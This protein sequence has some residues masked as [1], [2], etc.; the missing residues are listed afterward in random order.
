MSPSLLTTWPVDLVGLRG[1]FDSKGVDP[2]VCNQRAEVRRSFARI[3]AGGGG[4]ASNSPERTEENHCSNMGRALRRRLLD[5]ELQLLAYQC[6]R[7]RSL[8]ELAGT[9]DGQAASGEGGRI[10]G[11]GGDGSDTAAIGH[12]VD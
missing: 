7:S 4:R 2:D 5:Q 10:A 8:F 11:V 6:A 1:V 9:C 3:R 12:G